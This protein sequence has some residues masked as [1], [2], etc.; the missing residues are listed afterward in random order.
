MINLYGTKQHYMEE[1]CGKHHPEDS[2]SSNY[3]KFK[4]YYCL[5]RGLSVTVDFIGGFDPPLW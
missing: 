1:N 3:T 4:I 5:K 2:C